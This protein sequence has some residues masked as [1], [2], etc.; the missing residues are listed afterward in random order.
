M[1]AACFSNQYECA[2]LLIEYDASLLTNHPDIDGS[3]IHVAARH[4]NVL[5]LGLLIENGANVNSVCKS[6]TP[7][8]EAVAAGNLPGCRMLLSKG[9]VFKIFILLCLVDFFANLYF[10]SK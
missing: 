6:R 7:L 8:F 5:C 4:S 2:K 9:K 10:T 3:P 1:A